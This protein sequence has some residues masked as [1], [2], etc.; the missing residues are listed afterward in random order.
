MPVIPAPITLDTEV[1]VPQVLSHSGLTSR[2]SENN[3]AR[4]HACILGKYRQEYLQFKA[5]W[6]YKELQASQDYIVKL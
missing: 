6:L 4:Q 2:S 1:E 3:K 5:T